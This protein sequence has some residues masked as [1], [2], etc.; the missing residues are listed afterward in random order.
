MHRQLFLPGFPEGAVKI[1]KSLHILTKDGTVT[2]FVGGDNYFSHAET[3]EKS[4][5][6][7]FATLMHNNHVRPCDLAASPL[8]IPLRTLMNWLK[9]LREKGHDSFFQPPRR[10]S[11]RVMTPEKLAECGQLLA[12]GMKPVDVA[13]QAQIDESTLRKAIHRNAVPPVPPQPT[14]EPKGV[15]VRTKGERSRD[16]ANAASGIGT[17]CTRA[18]ERMQAA[19]GLAESATARFEAGKDVFMAG[20]LAG[21]PALCSNGLLSGIGN[22]LKLPKGF[23]GC[24]HILLTLGFMA[25]ARIRR[26]EGLRHVPPGELGKVIGLDRVPEVRT[27]REKITQMASMGNPEGW[28]KELT[29]SWMEQE[30]DEAGYLYVDGH[31]RVYHGKKANL[32][33]RYVSRE[34]LCLRGTTDYW[35]NDALGRPFF[36]VSKAVT[37]GLSHALIE[38]IVPSLLESVPEQ[39]SK[40]ELVEDPLLHRFV[41]VFDREGATHS[42]F[43]ALWEKRIGA[44]TYRKNVKDVWPEV[45]FQNYEIPVPGGGTTNMKLAQRETTLAAGKAHVP[46]IEVRRLTATGHQTAVITS[47]QRLET[48]TVAGRMFARWC[49]ENFFSYMMRHYDIDGL[50]QYGAEALPGTQLVVNPEW[51]CLDKAVKSASQK[52]NRLNARMGAEKEVDD[53][54]HIQK[55]ADILVEVQAAEMELERL[56]DQRKKT[57]RKVTLE[58]LPQEQR[59]T[60]LLPL[61]KQLV[62]SVKMI[63]YRAETALVALVRRF[64]TNE[65][66]ARALIR[67]LLVSSADIEPDDSAGTLTIKIHRMACPAHDKAIESLLKDLTEQSF[68]HPETGVRMIFVLV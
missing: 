53:E 16:D 63:A 67:E 32:P 3:D 17:A 26:P 8:A 42:L 34:R 21:L 2:Y 25:L 35:V 41:V 19:I 62:D 39:P 47:A 57:Q 20:L 37:E 11:G 5:R 60:K 33:R 4:K 1:G 48:K 40:A 27:L 52:V 43:A 51:R 28:M 58:S 68:C 12:T 31:V 38:D 54:T 56:R 49:Q 65:E 36:V 50:V 24:L 59:S 22:Y 23:Y 29:K 14:E 55:K 46:V 30:P 45:E 64:L 15:R 44:I 61:N 66:E 18:N 13:K 7:A 10:S 9:Q 6:F